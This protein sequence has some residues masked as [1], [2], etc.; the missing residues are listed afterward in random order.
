MCGIAGFVGPDCAP[1]RR[2]AAVARM[3]AAMERRGPD[4]QGLAST[5]PATLGMRRLAIFDPKN[6]RQPMVSPDGR[7]TL[8]FNGAIYNFRALRAELERSWSFRTECDTE[9]LLAAFS[10]WGADCL[11]RLR[12]MFAFAVWDATEQQLFLAR[13]PF[14]IKPLYF[15]QDG[16][17]LLFASELNALAASGCFTPEVDPTAAAEYLAWLAVPA[18]HTIY[19]DV[20]SL[21]PG[22]CAVFRAG[23]LKR[24]QWWHF[25]STSTDSS[26]GRVPSPAEFRTELRHRLDD[27]I[28]AHCLADVPVGAFLSGGLDSTVVVG[29][30]AR[31]F[32]GRLRTFSIGFDEAGF[33]E[34]DEAA[35]TAR[36]IGTDHRPTVV[37]GA[38]VA[39]DIE[40][41][42]ATLDHPTGDGINTYYVSRAARAGG[43]TVALSGLGGDELFGGY[44]SF[45]NLPRLA[46]WI[47]AWRMVPTAVARAL[48]RPLSFAGVR[49]EKMADMMARGRDRHALAAQQRRALSDRQC[50]RLLRGTPPVPAHPQLEILRHEVPD[51]DLFAVASAWELR[52]YMADLLLRDSDVMS[53][54]HSLELRVPFVDAPLIKWLWRQ[55]SALRSSPAHPKAVLAEATRDVLPPELLRRAKRGFTFPFA[56]WM[57]RELRPWLREVLSPESVGRTGLLDPCAVDAM[58]A[59]F[60]AGRDDRAWSRVWTTA[61]LVAF[62]NR[63]PTAV[64]A[65]A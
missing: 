44:P 29:L 40:R 23:E 36:F 45:R 60:F 20:A 24:K 22:A 26:S 46:P 17:Q 56:V 18:P 1:A 43:V 8:V 58:S 33:S 59:P 38:E 21:Q 54:A 50:R 37:R 53:M 14:G 6:G 25:P 3:C 19:R 10:R 34:A 62:I 63:R 39:R 32:T 52:G 12:G 27:A 30:M 9:V 49:G 28:A 65:A 7:F 51:S 13:D 41:I 11:P 31:Q 35:A 42:V 2:E 64:A 57:K 15:R 61:M 48:G 55:P 4:D 16:R 5:G 47:P